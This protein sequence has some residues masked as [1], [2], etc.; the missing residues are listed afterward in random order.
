MEAQRFGDEL[1]CSE[2]QIEKINKHAAED[3]L[4]LTKKSKERDK[5]LLDDIQSRLYK[6][7]FEQ[8]KCGIDVSCVT[9]FRRHI[10][11]KSRP[12]LEA[13]TKEQLREDRLKYPWDYTNDNIYRTQKKKDK[14]SD[15]KKQIK[16]FESGEEHV[17]IYPEHDPFGIYRPRP[18]REHRDMPLVN[19]DKF[20]N[21][22]IKYGSLATILARAHSKVVTLNSDREESDETKQLYKDLKKPLPQSEVKNIVPYTGDLY[23]SPVL[24]DDEE[25]DGIERV[26]SM[27]RS[28]KD[29]LAEFNLMIENMGKHKR[30]T[31]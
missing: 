14:A 25:L 8:V 3:Y 18:K 13:K 7:D 23:D 5:N 17:D 24:G 16:K 27:F 21:D 31:Y 1:P 20:A 12:P 29:D 15:K 4:E 11:H 2:V 6:L 22:H 10:Y 28:A 30:K 26:N 19:L 9:G